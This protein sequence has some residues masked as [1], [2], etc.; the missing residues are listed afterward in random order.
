MQI[1]TRALTG[2]VVALAVGLV[3]ACSSTPAATTGP[4][5][6]GQSQA[7]GLSLAIPSLAVP[8]LVIPSIAIPSIAIGG[9]GAVGADVEAVGKALVPPNSSEVT[10]TTAPDTWFVVYSSTDSLESLKSYYEATIPK[11]GLQIISTTTINGGISWVIAKDA[12]GSFGGAVSV[13]PSGDGKS[14]VQVTV[15]K[16]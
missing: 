13:F 10:K 5:G 3:G 8:S 2:I 1:R 11:T 7:P 12:S 9:G 6:G 4:G 15:G 14:V 16:S